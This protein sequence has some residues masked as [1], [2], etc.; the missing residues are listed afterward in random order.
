MLKVLVSVSFIAF[1]QLPSSS[2]ATPLEPR[3]PLL[4]AVGLWRYLAP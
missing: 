2:A 1:A 3:N 4:Y